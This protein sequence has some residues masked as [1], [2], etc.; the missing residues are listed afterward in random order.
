MKPFSSSDA[1]SG[2]ARRTGQIVP[3]LD[4]LHRMTGLL[5][6]ERTA[7]DARV[8]VLGAGGG[9]EL[10]VLAEMNPG[11][12]FVGVDPSAAML[13][14]ARASLGEL[15]SRVDFQQGY[16][17]SAPA[18]PFD[19]AVC[20]LTLHFLPEQDRLDTLRAISCRLKPGAPFVAA[21]HSFPNKGD[22]PDRWLARNAAFAVASGVPASQAA[23]SISAMKQRL[24]VLS[25]DQDEALMRDAGFSEV[26]QFYAAF[27]FKGWVGYR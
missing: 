25:P 16:I 22:G 15:A 3:G 2:Y 18:G 8:L 21:H 11:W 9:M 13:E 4:D 26:E 23:S 12:R 24:P 17:D 1:V 5:L 19:A 27:T 10:G 14:L 6:A 20:L 7:A